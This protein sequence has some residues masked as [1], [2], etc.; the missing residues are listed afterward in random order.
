MHL[1]LLEED[2]RPSPCT[3]E[4]L[5]RQ[6]TY[7]VIPGKCQLS[8]SHIVY[9]ISTFFWVPNCASP[10]GTVPCSSSH[11]LLPIS[12]NTTTSAG[13]SSLL[14]EI[15]RISR[16]L[17]NAGK[18]PG[19]TFLPTL[20]AVHIPSLDS[21]DWRPKVFAAMRKPFLPFRH[22]TTFSLILTDFFTFFYVPLSLPAATSPDTLG[23]NNGNW[24]CSH[25]R[26][27]FSLQS[28]HDWWGSRNADADYAH[29]EREK[30]ARCFSPY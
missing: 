26:F 4:N 22:E 24:R 6:S 19:H 18:W 16:H 17:G 5:Y 28:E 15:Q 10:L 1:H 12:A 29:L 9:S 2:V 25:L 13:R 14:A 30:A 7:L 8:L 11:Q 3:G 20:A 27:S 23:I 21:Q